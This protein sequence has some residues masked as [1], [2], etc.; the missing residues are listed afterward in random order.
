MVMLRVR[1]YYRSEPPAPRRVGLRGRPRIP[2]ATILGSWLRA[3]QAP[4]TQVMPHGFQLVPVVLFIVSN[5]PCARAD[6]GSSWDWGRSESLAVVESS[7]PRHHS[8]GGRVLIVV[9][10]CR[11]MPVDPRIPTC[12]NGPRRGFTDQARI[13]LHQTRK[14]LEVLGEWHER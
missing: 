6:R 4:H 8:G 9:H 14:R 7:H 11:R 10:G 12:R 2:S 13:C 3:R 5:I 1:L